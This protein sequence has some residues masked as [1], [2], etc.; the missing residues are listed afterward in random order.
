MEEEHRGE[1][2][3]LLTEAEH[4][5]QEMDSLKSALETTEADKQVIAGKARELETHVLQLQQ[6]LAQQQAAHDVAH[7]EKQAELDAAL[8]TVAGLQQE[9]QHT[10]ELLRVAEESKEIITKQLEQTLNNVAALEAK[11]QH[12]E[13][14]V[15]QQ[16]QALQEAHAAG[17]QLEQQRAVLTKEVEALQAHGLQVQEELDARVAEVETL[18]AE[19]QG[20]QSQLARVRTALEEETSALLDV[21]EEL[22]G[23]QEQHAA[24]M[25]ELEKTGKRLEEA[26]L[27]VVERDAEV[28]GGVS[29]VF[30]CCDIAI[31]H[32]YYIHTVGTPARAINNSTRHSDPT[33]SHLGCTAAA[34]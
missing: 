27:L 19:L 17:A 1:R 23:V 12:T 7:V 25:A 33:A 4:Y 21:R 30:C 31:Y 26:L 6:Q 10:A 28:W 20:T 5:L 2:Q 24:T 29:H 13:E 11:V 9:A 34:A 32:K 22:Q 3:H 18:Q 15:T 14:T 16:K 8:S